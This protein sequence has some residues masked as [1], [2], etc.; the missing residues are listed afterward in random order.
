MGLELLVPDNNEK[1]VLAFEYLKQ[2]MK[3]TL[4]INSKVPCGTGAVI[5]PVLHHFYV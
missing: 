2:G 4:E 1:P 5:L 3:F